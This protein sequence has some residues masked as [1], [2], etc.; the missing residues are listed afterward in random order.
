MAC[1]TFSPLTLPNLTAGTRPGRQ[2][3]LGSSLWDTVTQCSMARGS[4][5]LH[6]DWEQRTPDPE[7]ESCC[8][9]AMTLTRNPQAHMPEGMEICLLGRLQDR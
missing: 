6:G 3:S 9:K 1:S 8:E 2:A 7:G 4:W 5:P